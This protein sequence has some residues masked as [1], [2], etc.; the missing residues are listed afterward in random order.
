MKIVLNPNK[1]VVDIVKH[2]LEENGGYC[3]C[4]TE[5]NDDTRCM[6]TEFRTQIED[7]GFSGFCRCELYCKEE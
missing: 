5:K 2:G 4:Q 6:C 1:T 3:P 7:P